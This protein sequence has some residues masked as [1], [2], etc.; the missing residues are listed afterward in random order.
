MLEAISAAADR[1]THEVGPSWRY[2]YFVVGVLALVGT[3][4]WADRQLLSILLESIK[5]EFHFTDTQLG[6]LSGIA[7]G[8]FYAAVG[9][10]VAWLAERVSRRNL[11][12]LSVG[13]WSVM[14]AAGGLATGFLSLFAVR[15]GVGLAESGASP[16]SQSIVSDYFPQERRGF[17]MGLLYLYVP[18]GYVLAYGAGGFLNQ[19]VGWRQ[20]FVLVGLPGVLVALL[21]RLTVTEPRRGLSDPG[22][23]SLAIEG[24]GATARHFFRLRSLR[25]IPLA[26]AIHAI[27]AFGA[28]SWVPAFFIRTHGMTSLQAGSRLALLMASAGL[29]G[30]ILGGIL[31]DRLAAKT[32]NPALYAIVPGIFLLLSVPFTLLAFGARSPTMALL[33]YSVPAFCNHLILGPIVASM[34][35]LAGTRRRAIAAAYYSFTVN[36][37]S[38]GAGPLIV[39]FLSDRFAAQFGSNA[40]RY[41]LMSLISFTCAWAALHLFLA[42]RTIKWDLQ[43]TEEQRK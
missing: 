41:S 1:S 21:V 5:S 34:Q 4:S 26:G 8:L 13:I 6:L 29:A 35:N 43:Q 15:V 3:V 39:G 42:G 11:L 20:A 28:A 2:R 37:F 32:R 16:A 10:P 19:S 27:G 7:F 31:C 17:A 18:V 36:L 24:V 38:M 12:A 30:A 9:L 23:A 25:H 33:F 22:R 40:L 14:T